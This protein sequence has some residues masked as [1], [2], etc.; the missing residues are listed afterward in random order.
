MS[1]L[2]LQKRIPGYSGKLYYG[3]SELEHILLWSTLNYFRIHAQ[4]MKGEK[5]GLWCFV[6]KPPLPWG[7][8]SSPA[9]QR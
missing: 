2:S 7:I 8:S 3:I 5:C 9:V 1:L 6:Q 4:C